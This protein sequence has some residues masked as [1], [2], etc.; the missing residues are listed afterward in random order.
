MNRAVGIHGDKYGYDKAIYVK[1]CRKVDIW[2]KK[3]QK[4]F[5]QVPNSHL[6]GN[7]CKNCGRSMTTE[8]FIEKSAIIHNNVYGYD[9]V[10]YKDSKTKVEIYCK[11]CKKY[12]WQNSRN[13]YRGYGCINC[14]S[15]QLNS[16]KIRTESRRR[17]TKEYFV[18]KSTT[19]HGDKYGYDKVEY[20][21]CASKVEI[22]C[23]KCEKY[24][25]QVAEYHYKHGCP[26]CAIIN[27]TKTIEKFIEDARK[28]HKNIYDYTKVIYVNNNTNIEIVCN[29]C[30]K[31]FFQLPRA[32][33]SGSGCLNHQKST[34]ENRIQ[35]YLDK[36]NIKETRFPVKISGITFKPDFIFEING[37]KIIL[38]YDGI[39]HF[40]AVKF[41]GGENKFNDRYRC[42]RLK[43]KFCI[44]NNVN[45]IRISYKEL[46]NMNLYLDLFLSLIKSDEKTVYCVSNITLY[47]T[48]T[49]GYDNVVSAIVT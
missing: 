25:W 16:N 31:S 22:Y 33:L 4:Y 19:K 1:S 48:I 18:E 49:Q 13:H 44:E 3:C 37:K 12:F 7:G 26:K 34:G 2:C 6:S 30:K 41:F 21:G 23:K 45:L 8:E 10:K 17:N 32:H 35:E 24:F 29:I 27:T 20:K 15:G 46:N 47:D 39:Q 5:S 43:D 36:N 9:R 14:C 11:K 42:D 40:E 28:V 38:E